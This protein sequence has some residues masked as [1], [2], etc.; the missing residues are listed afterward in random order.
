MPQIN[1]RSSDEELIAALN[2]KNEEALNIFVQRY[3]R[4]V[5]SVGIRVLRDCGEAEDLAQEVFWHVFRNVER[6]NPRRGSARSW[7]YQVAW[8]KALNRHAYLSVRK[9]YSSVSWGEDRDAKS[10]QKTEEELLSRMLHNNVLR[11]WLSCLSQNER[12]TLELV[13]DKGCSLIEVSENLCQSLP[14]TR[15]YYYR[16]INKIKKF[17]NKELCP[18]SSTIALRRKS[19]EAASST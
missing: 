10:H 2:S 15:H 7:I 3:R 13:L 12:S 9:F 14:N 4:L 11:V 1:D 6:Y 8:G 5:F 19:E 18:Q 16:A 17:C